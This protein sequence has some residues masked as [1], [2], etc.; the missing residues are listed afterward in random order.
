VIHR[1]PIASITQLATRDHTTGLT[2]VKPLINIFLWQ[3]ISNYTHQGYGLLTDPASR[4]GDINM[5]FAQ[6]HRLNSRE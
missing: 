5:A 6:A 3:Y 1:C 4:Q 2:G